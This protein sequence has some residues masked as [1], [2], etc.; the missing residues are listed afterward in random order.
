MTERQQ[1]FH[2]LA[3]HLVDFTVSRKGKIQYAGR[4]FVYFHTPMFSKLI[5]NMREVTGPVID[6]EIHEFGETAGRQIASKLDHTF[7]E[8]SLSDLLRLLVSSGFNIPALRK[9]ASQD[10]RAQIEKIFG[11]GMYDG[12]VGEVLIKEYSPEDKTAVFEASNTFE[13]ESHGKTGETECS[14][15][16]G[17]LTGILSYYWDTDSLEAEETQC[18]C[19]GED[20]C[21]LRVGPGDEANTDAG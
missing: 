19:Q 16:A 6:K 12:W 9:I 8:S 13:S 20:T 15:I 5:N 10:D 17:V 3:P 1:A 7:K 4:R 2:K 21:Q 18:R 11:L 14:F